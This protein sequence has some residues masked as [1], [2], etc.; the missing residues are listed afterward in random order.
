MPS[1]PVTETSSG[2]EK[3]SA[4]ARD[5]IGCQ[6]QALS[7]AGATLGGEVTGHRL[8]RGDAGGGQ[9]GA[10]GLFALSA[11]D[12]PGCAGHV[13]DPDMAQLQQVLQQ[14]A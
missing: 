9:F 5:T 10:P 13:S 8:D 14:S 1:K 12:E 6:Q 2:T 4:V 11:V 7:R 3:P